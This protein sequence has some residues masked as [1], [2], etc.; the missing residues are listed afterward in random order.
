MREVLAYRL[1]IGGAPHQAFDRAVELLATWATNRY[2]HAPDLAEGDGEWKGGTG[3]R[4]W[5]YALEAPGGRDKLW[6]LTWH[7]PY[8][9]DPDIRWRIEVRVG[10]ERKEVWISLRLAFQ[11]TVYRMRP[12]EYELGAPDIV[13][14][15]MEHLEVISDGRRLSL[16]PETLTEHGIEAFVGLLERQA[17]ALPV[18]LVTPEET[19]R[20]PV[21][22][23]AAAA[24]SCAGL[25]HVFAIEDP[26][27]TF[28]LTDVLGK[29]RSAFWGAVRVY[30]PGFTRDADP[31]D[32]PLW[33]ADELRRRERE[34]PFPRRL[35]RLFA[36]ISVLRLPGDRLEG[37]IRREM[38]RARQEEIGELR[39]KARS[40]GASSDWEAELE[41]AW[42]EEERLARENAALGDEVEELR[43]RI[44]AIETNAPPTS[45]VEAVERAERESDYLVFLRE[46]HE[47]AARSPYRQPE[48][49]YRAL[50]ALD[51]IAGRYRRGELPGGW[52]IAFEEL[53]LD[54]RAD[55]SATAR[56]RFAQE[57]ERTWSGHRVMLGPHLALGGAGTPS[58]IARIYW[59]VD[60]EARLVVVG[61]V[62]MHLRDTTTG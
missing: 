15:L 25:A 52:K 43:A 36:P 19:T 27:V 48:R 14:P 33:Q 24:T 13:A 60:E 59:Y 16:A 22:D 9:D 49:V 17:R 7:R 4:L 58:T 20:Q 28:A 34:G 47:S 30:W 2:P 41:R 50:M 53:G 51:E 61:H 62:G 45:M 21:V 46:A 44:E 37:R 32:H 12:L 56:G 55:V 18:V 31:F 42:A 39:R 35:F 38:E 8:E 23:A 10:R 3:V 40:A 11:P 5:W 57:Y 54:F 29:V 26:E 1:P 6:T